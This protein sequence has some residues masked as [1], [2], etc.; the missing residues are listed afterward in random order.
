MKCSILKKTL[1]LILSLC[2]VFS[3]TATGISAA[4]NDSL[5]PVGA[6]A[7]WKTGAKNLGVN[8]LYTTGLVAAGYALTK[9]AAATEC[10]EFEKIASFI[11]VWVCGGN[12]T[13]QTLAEITALC[14]QILSELKHIEQK[15]DSYANY[16]ATKDAKDEYKEL[17]EKMNSAWQDDVVDTMTQYG[18]YFAML[19]FFEYEDITAEAESD[20]NTDIGYFAAASCLANNTP[21]KYGHTYTEEEVQKKREILFEE[22]CKMY[23]GIDKEAN[24]PEKKAEI[25]FST[26][27]IDVQMQDAIRKLSSDINK[28]DSYADRCAQVAYQSIPNLSDQYEYVLNGVNRQFMQ[29]CMVELLYQEYLSMRGEYL[30]YKYNQAMQS[31]DKETADELLTANK[32]MWEAYYND[33]DTFERYNKSLLGYMEK[34]ISK[35]L[36]LDTSVSLA[37]EDYLTPEDMGSITL[38]NTAYKSRTDSDDK[39]NVYNGYDS[40]A[41]YTTEYMSFHRFAVVTSQGVDTYYILDVDADGNGTSDTTGISSENA[42]TKTMVHKFDHNALDYYY[43]SCDAYNL[44]L[45]TYTDGINSFSCPASPAEVMTLY[46][47]GSFDFYASTPYYYLNEFL[48]YCPSSNRVYQMF[49]KSYIDYKADGILTDDH[50]I[51]DTLDM[52][53]AYI[54]FDVSTDLVE[55]V[56]GKVVYEKDYTKSG[57]DKSTYNSYYT[58]ILKEQSETLKNTISLS[59]TGD[60]KAD[61]Y[62][63]DADGNKIANGSQVTCGTDLTLWVKATDSATILDSLKR[64]KCPNP[65]SAD[66]DESTEVL[67]EREN[68]HSLEIDEATG[69]YKLDFTM[70]YSNTRFEVGTVKGNSITYL[71]TITDTPINFYS[72]SNLHTKGEEIEFIYNGNINHIYLSTKDSVTPVEMTYNYALDNS[73]GKF[74]MPEGDATLLVLSNSFTET[75]Y[76]LLESSQGSFVISDYEDLLCM[77]AFINSGIPEYTKAQYILSDS[78]DMTG[79]EWIPIKSFEGTFDGQGNTISNLNRSS[80]AGEGSAEPLFVSIENT[81]TVKNLII[82]NAYVFPSREGA[83]A[84]SGFNHGTVESCLVKNSS[85]QLGNWNYLGGLTGCNTGK[86]KNC[87]IADS[88]LTRRWGGSTSKPMGGL[89]QV[90]DGFIENCFV[91]N[92]SFTNGTLQNNIMIVSGQRSPFDSFYTPADNAKNTYYTETT[93]SAFNS[94]EVAYL[95]NKGVTDGTQGWYQTLNTDSYPVPFSTHGTVYKN[96]DNTY[97]NTGN[98]SSV[99][100]PVIGGEHTTPTTPSG[101]TDNSDTVNK[102]IVNTGMGIPFMVIFTVIMSAVF[103]LTVAI[104]KKKLKEY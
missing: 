9:I 10:E 76:S 46:S 25:L 43:S 83:G 7:M 56:N 11:N 66:N 68:F 1:A 75:Y 99:L 67:L 50:I 54:G 32:A 62:I 81:A 53:S 65:L 93:I 18:V 86:I 24:T 28:E 70:P 79:K 84:I 58:V 30:E 42:K 35:P 61:A 17:V 45:C 69:Y 102:D 2:L 52:N 40:D 77:S 15:M 73:H 100:P 29:I 78:I 36:Q 39:T 94:G 12:P 21:D 26:N 41:A 88:S 16:F 85:I 97:S 98:L 44:R 13:T 82:D 33:I 6:S 96:T 72:Y 49:N 90:N 59:V 5:V 37:L 51:Y 71:N 34:R 104:K 22:F 3:V 87:G 4:T 20:T 19:D 63:T 31:P 89:A 23:G 38:H 74:T 95:L 80:I 48:S 60:G 91:Y 55:K 27:K 103:L 47:T 101:S 92:C 57:Y 64:Y 14:N 8:K